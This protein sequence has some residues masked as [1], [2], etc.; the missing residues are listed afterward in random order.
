[1]YGLP[2]ELSTSVGLPEAAQNRLR[3]RLRERSRMQPKFP[4]ISSFS[5]QQQVQPLAQS[6][7]LLTLHLQLLQ[8]QLSVATAK[9]PRGTF[10]AAKLQFWRCKA[11]S[12]I[13]TIN[14]NGCVGC[15]QQNIE[16]HDLKHGQQKISTAVYRRYWYWPG[17]N[18]ESL[19]LKHSQQCTLQHRIRSEAQHN[20]NTNTGTSNEW[21]SRFGLAVSRY[22]GW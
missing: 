10:L 15:Q 6:L 2:T 5:W 8:A 20:K 19:D 17:N 21:V 11:L 3:E 7:T 14:S 4:V 1:M 18:T 22:W 13:L 12:P 9:M 16:H